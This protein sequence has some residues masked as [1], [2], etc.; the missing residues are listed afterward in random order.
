MD[1]SGRMAYEAPSL[2]LLCCPVV[3]MQPLQVRESRATLGPPGIYDPQVKRAADIDV[4]ALPRIMLPESQTA[5]TGPKGDSIPA[6]LICPLPA[7]MR[8]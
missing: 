2:Y 8:R 5:V 6:M 7:D 4:T 1:V 3:V